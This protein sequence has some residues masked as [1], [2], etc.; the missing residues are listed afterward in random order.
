MTT[1]LDSIDRRLIGALRTSP[2]STVTSLA[3]VVG[4]TRSTIQLRL[5]RLVTTGTITGFGPDL[6]PSSTRYSVV[7]FVTLSIAQGAHAAV[8][9]HLESVPEVLE[10]HTVT[11]GGDLLCKVVAQSNSDLHHVVQRVVASPHVVRTETH[12]SLANPISRKLAD[13]VAL[14][15]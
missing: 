13:L 8:I 1:G 6:D 15:D 7:A 12:L 2:R 4:V 5:D 9:G 10:V 11:G 3:Q 14:E